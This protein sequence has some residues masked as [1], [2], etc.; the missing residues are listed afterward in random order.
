MTPSHPK[1]TGE[2]AVPTAEELSTALKPL[3][4]ELVAKA[5]QA[6]RYKGR[7]TALKEHVC[8]RAATAIAGLLDRLATQEQPHD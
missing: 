4:D 5:W 7:R 1:G 8:H 6:Q 2:Q 3:I